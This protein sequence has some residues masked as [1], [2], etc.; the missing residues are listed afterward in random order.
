MFVAVAAG[1]GAGAAIDIRTRRIPNVI[2]FGTA[3]LGLVL[4]AT[5]ASGVTLGSSLLG[6]LA[7]VALM[8]PGRLLGASGMG[9]V[10]LMAAVGAVVGIQRIPAAFIGTAIVGGT[11]AIVIAVLRR[12]LRATLDGTGKILTAP[13]ASR[14]FIERAGAVN[15][16]SYGPAIA[17]G[18]VLA[19]W[20]VR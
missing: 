1:A 3:A 9:D 6:W 8:L 18:G 17:A 2:T 5:G 12:R 7:G 10:K 11:L 16:F 15:R 14:D 13:T 4:A 19:A 20:F